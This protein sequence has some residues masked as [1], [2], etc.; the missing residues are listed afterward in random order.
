MD[1][2]IDKREAELLA[3]LEAERSARIAER[4]AAGEIVSVPLFIVAGSESEVRLQVEAAKAAKLAELHEGGDRREVVFAVNVVTTGV[5]RPGEAA[6]APAWKP[7]S[8]PFLLSSPVPTEVEAV[9]DQEAPAPPLFETPFCVQTRRCV[10]DDDPGEIAEGWCSV[11]DGKVVTVTD[12]K[13]G[14]VGS[15][16]MI[17]GEDPKTVAKKLLREKTP[18]SEDFNRVLHYPSVGLA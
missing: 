2:D 18:E 10:D 4:I 11:L 9:F 5:L 6:E 13:G 12:A 8:P 17:E 1:T 7:V 15:R 3:R 16:R 14:Y